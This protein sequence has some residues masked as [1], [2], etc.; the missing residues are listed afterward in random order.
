MESDS[1]SLFKSAATYGLS[2][3]VIVIIYNL[4]I[5]FTGIMAVGITKQF[6]LAVVII[7]IYVTGIFIFTKRTRAEL[8]EGEMTFKQAWLT[9]TYIGFFAAI[10][11]AAYSYLQNVIIDPDYLARYVEAQTQYMSN[12]M[13]EKGVPDNQIETLI[14]TLQASGEMDFTFKTYILSVFNNTLGFSVISLITGAILKNK[15]KNP[16]Q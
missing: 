8:Y 16:F 7:A 9:G 3:G 1:K 2:L 12:Y 11:I 6:L 14:E 5:Y 10:V 4:I 13:F 15:K